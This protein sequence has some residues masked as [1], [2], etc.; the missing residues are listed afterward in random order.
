MF[1]LLLLF[2]SCKNFPQEKLPKEISY[3][4]WSN[5]LSTAKGTTVNLMMW[6][7]DA[8]INKYM[9]DFVVPQLKSKYNIDLKISAGQGN[10]IVSLVM[11][12]KQAGKQNQMDMCWING[13]TFYQ[14]RQIDGL[15]GP[16]TD[17]LPNSKH[18][19][20]K[21]QFIN[22]DF[23]QPINGMECPWGNVQLCVIYDSLKV[24][25]PPKNLTEL[26]QWVKINPEKFTIG[27]DFTGLTVLKSWMI[28]IAGGTDSLKGNFNEEKYQ[29]YSKQLWSYINNT[30]QYWWKEGKT[31]PNAVAPM[32]QMFANGELY[33]TMSNNDGDVDNKVLQGFFPE[34]SRSYVYDGGTIQN[35][36]Y[37]GILK[38]AENVAGAMVVCNFLI[39]K[40]AQFEK[41][42][43][44]VWG[45]GTVLDVTTLDGDWQQ[46]FATL[47]ARKYGP[48]RSQIQSK[49]LPEI[50]AEYMI[51]LNDD[52]R[53]FVI[54][55]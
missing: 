42:K 32:H 54:E 29:K 22:T 28:S 39:S 40:E 23:Q 48:Q 50:A 21:N 25:S 2:F 17:Q 6:T 46:K 35:S 52:F 31:F 33:F 26:A 4:T 11:N 16:F 36:H 49:A 30:K 14:L 7:G 18:I 15:Y 3:M 41:M 20:F 8:F 53:K 43:T 13:E 10:Q 9:N 51:R 44:N 34:S 19:D 45:D 24:P 1:L 27:I 5:I 55:K 12:E 37:M 38:N 47:A